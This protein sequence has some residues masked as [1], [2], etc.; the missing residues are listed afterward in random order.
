VVVKASDRR[1]SLV[2]AAVEVIAA[3]GVEGATT[4]RIAAAAGASLASLHY[5]FESKEALFFAIWENQV[6]ALERSTRAGAR[7]DGLGQTANRLLRE[8]FDWFRSDEPYARVQ[9]E[10]TF[11]ALRQDGSLGVRTYDLHTRV[12]RQGLN[13]GLLP[14]ED[15]SVIDGLARLIVALADGISVQWMCYRDEGRLAEDLDNAQAALS[16][17]LHAAGARAH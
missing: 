11:W 4:R 6:D 5:V 16:G 17:F 14:G 2:K 13:D 12:M 15:A 1:S 10:L 7:R 9:L 3:H 8:T